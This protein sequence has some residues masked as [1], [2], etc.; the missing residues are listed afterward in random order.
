[1]DSLPLEMLEYIMSCMDGQS[2][3]RAKAVC[4][5]WKE[6]ASLFD[7]K[8]SHWKMLCY[9]DISESIL[10]ESILK[11]YPYWQ[12][13]NEENE[14]INWK[15]LYLAWVH[16][17]GLSCFP[18]YIDVLSEEKSCYVTCLK[19]VGNSI[20]VGLLNGEIKSWKAGGGEPFLLSR[21]R[22]RVTCLEVLSIFDDRRESESDKKLDYILS[23][24][25]DRILKVTY[26]IDEGMVPHFFDIYHHE[27]S[28]VMVRVLQNYFAT[29]DES[30]AVAVFIVNKPN[31]DD[32][33]P[34]VHLIAH[35][36]PS[37]PPVLSLNIWGS[38]VSVMTKDGTLFAGEFRKGEDPMKVDFAPENGNVHVTIVENASS[39]VS[40]VNH[41][42]GIEILQYYHWRNN[43]FMWI[44]DD[45]KMLISLNGNEYH[46]YNMENVLNTYPRTALLYG[47]MLILGLDSGSVVIYYVETPEELL[48]LDLQS[49]HWLYPVAKEAVLRM[50]VWES[51]SGPVLGI[52]TRSNVY[53]FEW[54]CSLE[55]CV[56]G[57]VHT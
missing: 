52:F 54:S 42:K 44:T 8:Q 56:C 31:L 30:G 47:N 11:K 16:W 22:S 28:T 1:M 4:K 45:H 37:I 15:E 5:K 14:Q 2:L 33:M 13:D 46:E 10:L 7:K 39:Y 41:S 50:D 20:V 25:N 34:P 53:L 23:T 9:K 49:Y 55:D 48:H 3:I 43:I 19:L 57:E 36:Q 29:L 40:K 38:K 17:K 27:H 12:P 35:Y 18:F 51:S 26:L 32:V 24:S 6:V 21:H